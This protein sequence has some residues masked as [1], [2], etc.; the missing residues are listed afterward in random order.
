MILMS[1]LQCETQA[2]GENMFFI[3]PMIKL[4]MFGSYISVIGACTEAKAQVI[5]I[6]TLFSYFSN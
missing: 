2:T 1:P 6:C 5:T 4:R 3:V